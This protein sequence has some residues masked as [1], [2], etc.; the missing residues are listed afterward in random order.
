MPSL[1]AQARSLGVLDA[2][3]GRDDLPPLPPREQEVV[4]EVR[5]AGFSVAVK[6]SI[7]ATMAADRY[8][9]DI[10]RENGDLPEGLARVLD[11]LN[12]SSRSLVESQL[13]LQE[14]LERGGA[15]RAAA[16]QPWARV[17]AS[18]DLVSG[19]AAVSATRTAGA[20]VVRFDRSVADCA[21]TVTPAGA[22]PVDLSASPSG[23]NVLV[24]AWDPGGAPVSAGFSLVLSC[25]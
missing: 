19:S 16:T 2:Q 14:A 9:V 7:Y 11:I 3:V 17:D 6:R 22:A 1:T 18:G 12:S 8:I 5:E 4:R 25:P 13:G 21:A 20:T 23:S 10:Q 24:R 15:A